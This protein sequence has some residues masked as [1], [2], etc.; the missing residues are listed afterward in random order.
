MRMEKKIFSFLFPIGYM[1]TD[2]LCC[3]YV[4]CGISEFIGIFGKMSEII[5]LDW[6]CAWKVIG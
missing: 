2:K 4:A 1:V 6:K 5:S 3:G